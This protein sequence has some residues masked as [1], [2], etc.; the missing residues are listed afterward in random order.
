MSERERGSEREK[1]Y[2]EFRHTE[3]KK[4][5]G[6][7]MMDREKDRDIAVESK[8]YFKY[9]ISTVSGLALGRSWKIKIK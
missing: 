7:L 8:K 5:V 4:E 2:T 3:I 6:K 9:L 1:G